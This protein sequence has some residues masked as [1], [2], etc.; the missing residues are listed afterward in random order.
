M[1]PWL[2]GNRS[3]VFPVGWRPGR[4]RIEAEVHAL[5]NDKVAVWVVCLES[6]AAGEGA[7]WV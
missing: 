3:I 6:R 7:L 2:N 1:G 4:S 5:H